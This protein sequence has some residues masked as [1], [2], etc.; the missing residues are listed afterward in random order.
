MSSLGPLD[1]PME[2]ESFFE[3]ANDGMSISI[4]V[5]SNIIE[6]GGRTFGFKVSQMES[7]IFQF[8]GIAS[9]FG[10]FGNKLLEAITPAQFFKGIKPR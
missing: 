9:A 7:E 5:N 8:G 10:L 3:L 6:V 1:I 2:Y 4:H